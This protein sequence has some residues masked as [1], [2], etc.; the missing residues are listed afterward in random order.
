MKYFIIKNI[1]MDKAVKIIVKHGKEEIELELS[2]D[3][4]SRIVQLIIDE[5]T[6]KVSANGNG[7]DNEDLGIQVRKIA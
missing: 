5:Y 2:N 7:K 4:E 6:K 1:I 3:L